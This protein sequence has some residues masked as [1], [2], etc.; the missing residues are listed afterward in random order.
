[1]P[2]VKVL[3]STTTTP[4][5]LCSGDTLKP[6]AG[7]RRTTAVNDRP[8]FC[9]SSSLVEFI[10]FYTFDRSSVGACRR[11]SSGIRVQRLSSCYHSVHQQ[12]TYNVMT[13]SDLK[14]ISMEGQGGNSTPI[15]KST[16]FSEDKHP[17]ART[18]GAIG[19][20]RSAGK[21]FCSWY[22]SFEPRSK[23]E[24]VCFQRVL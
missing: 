14:H 6:Q 16:K 12:S 18:N 2:Q 20:L 17:D 19:C 15:I 23:R 4:L 9:Q 8:A 13:S 22:C 3:L 24:R 1:M 7:R 10:V 11:S 21:F 5:L